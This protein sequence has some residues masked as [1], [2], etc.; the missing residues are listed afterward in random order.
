MKVVLTLNKTA[1]NIEHKKDKPIVKKIYNMS[2]S[3][4][5]GYY[6]SN[7]IKEMHLKHK[8]KLL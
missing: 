4:K 1:S 5:K 3:N 6:S 2:N 8:L 7:L